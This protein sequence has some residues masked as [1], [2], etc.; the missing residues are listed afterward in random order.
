MKEIKYCIQQRLKL[1]QSDSKGIYN[2]TKDW[3]KM[4]SRLYHMFYKNT[5]QRF[6]VVSFSILEWFVKDHVTLKLQKNSFA[7]TEINS[8]LKYILKQK[9]YFK[10]W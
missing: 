8:I 10:L 4:K 2:I 9:S 1:I 7:I 5:M 3:K 6:N